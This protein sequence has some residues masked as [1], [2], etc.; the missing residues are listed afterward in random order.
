MRSFSRFAPW[1]ATAILIALSAMTFSSLP[2]RVPQ[3]FGFDGTVTATTSRSLLEWMLLPAIAVLTVLLMEGIS[4]KLPTKPHLFNYPG[5][6]DLLAL[7]A[8]Y[9]APVIVA[10]QWTLDWISFGTVLILLGVQWLRWHVATGG[11]GQTGNVVLLLSIVLSM[12]LIFF[13]VGR[14]GR[15]TDDAKERHHSMTM[16]R[17]GIKAPMR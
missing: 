9:Q 6:E 1:V 3:R 13:L 7:P 8:E 17:P 10:M 14:V 16:G 12:P 4:R 5:K 11:S 15:A 2:D